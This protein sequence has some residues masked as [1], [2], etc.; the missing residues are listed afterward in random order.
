MRI[1]L[2]C[3]PAKL[4]KKIH[5]LR[6]TFSFGALP[7]KRFDSFRI[8]DRC[9]P[10]GNTDPL[11]GSQKLGARPIVAQCE[12]CEIACIS[13]LGA[14]ANGIDGFSEF[15]FEKPLEA[16]YR[17][18]IKEN[19]FRGHANQ[20]LSI[21][22]I[23]S[24]QPSRRAYVPV[25]VMRKSMC[26]EQCRLCSKRHQAANDSNAKAQGTLRGVRF[27]FP[28]SAPLCSRDN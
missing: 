11:C 25:Y 10:Q 4:R 27:F 20:P 26:L 3:W 14:Q 16:S 5:S 21:M 2:S 13:I 18:G 19:R 1:E 6:S 8:D 15:A 23:R 28:S 12:A 9:P 22:N 7:R 24:Q 17:E